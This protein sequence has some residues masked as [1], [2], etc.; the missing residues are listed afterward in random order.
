[1]D[2]LIILKQEN[3]TFFKKP[4]IQANQPDVCAAQIHAKLHRTQ[5][6]DLKRMWEGG[7]MLTVPQW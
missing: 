4:E 5:G 2:H 7:E 1:M 6:Q 3:K